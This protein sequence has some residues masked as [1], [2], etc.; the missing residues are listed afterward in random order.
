M[1]ELENNLILIEPGDD[2]PPGTTKFD[3]LEK[4][5]DG[6]VIARPIKFLSEQI[7]GPNGK[8]KTTWI[9]RPREDFL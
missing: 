2:M 5:P 8:Y 3:V 4:R 7:I 1:K 6:V 9:R